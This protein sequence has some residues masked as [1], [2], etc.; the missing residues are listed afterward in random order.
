[1]NLKKLDVFFHL[2][3]SASD[4]S[5][6]LQQDTM[7]SMKAP[8]LNKDGAKRAAINIA[9][10]I[11]NR[12]A[13]PLEWLTLH[14]GRTGYQ[15]RAQTYLMQA[16]LQLRRDKNAAIAGDDKY[17]VRGNQNWFGLQPLEDELLLEED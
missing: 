6:A 11:S 8:P 3:G 4:Y 15:D 5:E 10:T 7:G 13:K 14:F 2:P 17:E 1:M 9:E 12:Q 16:K